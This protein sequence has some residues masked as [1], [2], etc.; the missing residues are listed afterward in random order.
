MT[1]T[2]IATLGVLVA[3]VLAFA[4]LT[5][6][7]SVITA[8]AARRQDVVVSPIRIPRL[9]GMDQAGVRRLLVDPADRRILIVGFIYTRCTNVCSVLGNTYQQLQAQIEDRHLEAK[10][11]LVTLSFDP[12]HDDPAAV[13]TYAL[14][15]RANPDVWTIL[16]PSDAGELK[17]T[18]KSFGIIATPTGDGQFVHNGAFHVI[19]RQG[20]L[21]RIIDLDK[22]QNAIAAGARLYGD[23]S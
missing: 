5:R 22:P 7:F 16:S 23:Q 21:A 12:E 20:R 2:L 18:L 19:D 8:E 13:A 9:V 15:L 14:R 3:G 11:H 10:I 6:G 4:H 17:R 1:R